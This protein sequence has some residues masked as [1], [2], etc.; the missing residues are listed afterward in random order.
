MVET[1]YSLANEKVHYQVSINRYCLCMYVLRNNIFMPRKIFYYTKYGTQICSRRLNLKS[2]W[3]TSHGKKM[4]KILACCADLC[5]NSLLQTDRIPPIKERK[6]NRFLLFI[7]QSH[8]CIRRGRSL[9]HILVSVIKIFK[10]RIAAA[11]IVLAATVSCDAFG[12]SSNHFAGVRT[13]ER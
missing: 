2:L 12:V 7:I 11:L 5:P 13:G 6:K 8:I 4:K 3:K 9:P 1:H 10:M